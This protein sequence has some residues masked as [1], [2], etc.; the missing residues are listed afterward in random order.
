MHKA[1]YPYTTTPS[2]QGDIY[3]VQRLNNP[4]STKLLQTLTKLGKDAAYHLRFNNT[5][6]FDLPSPVGNTVSLTSSIGPTVQLDY[7]PEIAAPGGTILNLWPIEGGGYALISGTSM[8]TPYAAAVFALIK[9]QKPK[10]SVDE[11]VALVKTT[12]ESKRGT[13]WSDAV[14][15][16]PIEQGS[17]LINAYAAV[18]ADT[19]ISPAQ[20]T[21]RDT[22]RPKRQVI[23]LKNTSPHAQTYLVSHEPSGLIAMYNTTAPHEYAF[24]SPEIRSPIYASIKLSTNVVSLTP[25]AQIDV[26]IDVQPPTDIVPD[27]REVYGGYIRIISEHLHYTV[28]YFASRTT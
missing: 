14:Q 4:D 21:L 15:A 7:K 1:I 25:G 23:T 18:Y 2:E 17:G 9:S 13:F 11:I 5:D 8:A 28:P 26:Q 10:M 12:C 19:H 6:S 27:N 16:S 22:A 3:F 24:V 20:L